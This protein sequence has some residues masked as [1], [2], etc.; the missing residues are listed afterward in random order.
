M[1]MARSS[2][3][4][5]NVAQQNPNLPPGLQA[6]G[7]PSGQGRASQFFLGKDPQFLQFSPYTQNQMSALQQLLQMGLGGMQQQNFSFDPIEQRARTMFQEQTIP[8]LAERFAGLGGLRS[9][10]FQT[11]LGRQA[12][13]L[14]SQLAGMRSQY[15]MNLLPFYQN[16]ATIG[17][18]PQ[19]ES[20]Y[21]P[22]GPG[23]VH[24]AARGIGSLIPFGAQMAG[25]YMGLPV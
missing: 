8:S 14:E 10:A 13:D 6:S 18:T 4:P 9:S 22:G 24:A 1:N 7:V 19:Y 23:A 2:R 17:L 5:Q 3:N 21:A 11:S 25:R 20:I 12:S 16:L 15:N